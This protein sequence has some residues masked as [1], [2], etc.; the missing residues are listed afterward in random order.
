MPAVADARIVERTFEAGPYVVGAYDGA[1]GGETVRA[2]RMDGSIV[3]MDANV[4]DSDGHVIPQSV[5]MLHHLVFKDQGHARSFRPDAA[6]PT[7]SS[8]ERFF[9]VSEELRALTLPKGYGYRIEREDRWRMGWMLMNHTHRTRAAW[10]RYHVRIDTSDRLRHVTPYWFSVLGCHV[11]PAY[12]VAGGDRGGRRGRTFRVPRAG[13]IVAVGG[14]LHGGSNSIS[15]AQPRCDRT[16]ITNRPT[17]GQPDDPVY[18]VR[19]LLHEPDPRNISWWQSRTGIPVRKGERL[20]VVAR[21]RDDFPY[22]RVMG[23]DHVYIA[24]GSAPGGCADPPKDA[25]ELGPDFVGRDAPPHMELTLARMDDDGHAR[26]WDGPGG[27]PAV[28]DDGPAAVTERQYA[29]KPARVSIPAGGSVRWTFR[30]EDLHDATLVTGPRGFSSPPMLGGD[31]AYSHRFRV[32]GTYKVYCS[33]HP[34]EMQQVVTVRG[35]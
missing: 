16:L 21:Y 26:P 9:G 24:H 7:T 3:E 25:E 29:F 12:T 6:C 33:L 1:R 22:M 8:D 35:E 10:I 5:V 11:D 17:Y 23:I 27:S 30:D 34:V 15:L 28:F 14:H 4:V 2:P 19:P 18:A 31:D 20:R 32:P 13:R